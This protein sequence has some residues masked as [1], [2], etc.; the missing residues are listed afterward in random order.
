[1]RP[2]VEATQAGLLEGIWWDLEGPAAFD[3]C[4][5]ERCLAAFRDFAGIPAEE[6]LTPLSIQ[7]RHGAAWVDFACRQSA[8]IAARMQ[9]YSRAA[10]GGPRIA[11]Y[12]G[13]HSEHTRRAYRVDWLT[14]TPEI[15]VATPSFYSFSAAALSTTFTTGIRDFTALVRKVRDIPVWA[16]LSTGYERGSYFTNDGRLTKMQI[17]KS[18]AYGADGTHQWWWG[19]MD[20]RHYQA[21]AEATTLI[22][23][24]EEFFTEGIVDDQFL[25]GEEPGGTTRIARRLGDR[26]LVMMFNDEPTQEIIITA[27]TPEGFRLVRSDGG[28]EMTLAGGLLT[29]QVPSLDCRWAVLEGVR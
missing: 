3:V 21:Y 10:G 23:G 8:R 12:S 1:M 2:L 16:T 13:T 20:G 15:D 17:I 5:C 25:G 28:P 24:L 9:S 4:F 22:A 7:A 29:A 14:L 27:R 19:P 11:I 18:V 26:T 6:Q